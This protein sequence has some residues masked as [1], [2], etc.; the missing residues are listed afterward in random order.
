M[1][2]HF[3]FSDGRSKKFWEVTVDRRT[4]TVRFGR[5]GTAGQ[6][7]TKTFA[8]TEAAQAAA[9]KQVG[10]KVRGGYVET[11]AEPTPR[12]GAKATAKAKSPAP[13][14]APGP[15]GQ[16]GAIR[17]LLGA[18]DVEGVRQG[19]ALLEALGDRETWIMLADGVSVDDSWNVVVASGSEIHRRVKAAFREEVALRALHG[20][21]QSAKVKAL[22]LNARHY[23]DLQVVRGYT[24]L[25][26]LNAKYLSRLTSLD[27]VQDLA[28]LESLNL[29]SCDSLRSVDGLRG[30]D[31]LRELSLSGC[32]ALADITALGG[33]TS[34]AILSLC[35]CTAV[36]SL[37]PLGALKRLEHLDLSASGVTDLRGI[38][39]LTALSS[40][41]LGGMDGLTTVRPLTSLRALE[42]LSL[43]LA[44]G[45]AELDGLDA[46]TGLKML[47]LSGSV[48][49]RDLRALRA[50]RAL[51]VLNLSNCTALADLDGVQELR[52]LRKLDLTSCAA[53]S[54]ESLALLHGAKSL[55][56][57]SLWEVTAVPE[58][59]RRILHET[60]VGA[61]LEA[62]RSE[63]RQL[64]DLAS[65][66][67]AL[68]RALE[69]VRRSLS[70]PSTLLPEVAEALFERAVGL[71]HSPQAAAPRAE[72]ATP[73]QRARVLAL[74][75][76]GDMASVHEGIDLARALDDA[77]LW[78]HL[79]TGLSV[80][81]DGRIQMP[82]D[83]VV[84]QR[85]KVAF[86]EEV[87]LWAM[88][89]AG[90]LGAVRS[91]FIESG[92]LL[93]ADPL[94]G[95]S[96][97]TALHIR[98]EQIVDAEALNTLTA[99]EEL[100]LSAG[101]AL[102]GFG[103]GGLRGLV[104]LRDLSLGNADGLQDLD[105]IRGL[106]RLERLHVY[107]AGIVGIER[108]GA[109]PRLR[110]LELSDCPKLASLTGCA[111][112]PRLEELTITS[113]D[114][115]P[116]VRGIR[117]AKRLKK[118]ELRSLNG[119]ESL[120]GLQGL[121]ALRDLFVTSESL[122]HLGAL[123]DLPALKEVWLSGCRSLSNYGAL[124][125]LPQ[126]KRL[127]LNESSHIKGL[128]ALRDLAGSGIEEL[129]LR[130]SRGLSSLDGI[131]A[132]GA[133]RSLDLRGC[134]RLKRLA[135]LGSLRSLKSLDLTETGAEWDHRRELDGPVLKAFLGDLRAT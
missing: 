78:F 105:A 128:S 35:R 118:V 134:E 84:R 108:M 107:R 86:R 91:L 133:L 117:G 20:A 71:A 69:T 27:G 38:E 21:G 100:S 65:Q 88:A 119:L 23:T 132:L 67:V 116:D 76:K 32:T 5:I 115:L 135:P 124:A 82:K 103:T 15:A 47:D 111:N 104:V 1:A 121:P 114:A 42:S 28:A 34:L 4:V 83:S 102:G 63:I 56:R 112:L 11:V 19:I 81:A 49:V 113:C 122:T 54:V 123:V 77:E 24:K 130:W 89:K 36:T 18:G 98:A 50:L 40:L 39:R 72:G 60:K 80:D 16:L 96:A 9:E 64:Q 2:R 92:S 53:L 125:A 101:A 31:G 10:E 99:L 3:E 59:H 85:V 25:E 7:Q 41:K 94:R 17:K 97:L 87:A 26:R 109:L 90:T 46:L 29:S 126:L 79:A 48:A 33:L 57:L 12:V 127:Y 14:A 68:K 52:A 37:A 129:S 13:A 106:P 51:E 30:L 61:F 44:D 6:T 45:M 66:G 74:I 131:E 93:T 22:D 95:L 8:S 62:L 120:E 43:A 55:V 110:R 70:V 58:A 75:G 73:T